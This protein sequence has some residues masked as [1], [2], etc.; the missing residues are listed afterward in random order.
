M[1]RIAMAALALAGCS[2]TVAPV[3]IG[4]A[5]DGLLH[6]IEACHRN[7]IDGVPV[8]R[9]VDRYDVVSGISPPGWKLAGEVRVGATDRGGCN[10]YISS[11]DGPE[12]RNLALTTHFGMS[13]RRWIP[14]KIIA[15]PRGE[16][17][18]AICTT[19][20]MPAGKSVG[21]VM[22]SRLDSTATDRRAFI[23]TVMLAAASDCTERQIF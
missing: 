3:E 4:V 20:R 7:V 10:I 23:A 22:T 17:R 18:D 14:M 16:V 1:T 15:A 11:G 12:L 9:A 13:S 19:D 5:S 2:T 8:D 6:G 21:V